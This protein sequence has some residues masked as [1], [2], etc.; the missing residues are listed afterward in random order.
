MEVEAARAGVC[1]YDDGVGWEFC[2][3]TV[4]SLT[5]ACWFAAGLCMSGWDSQ[6]TTGLPQ[7]LRLASRGKVLPRRKASP[8]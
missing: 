3:A 8:D 2:S 1:V 4:V 5:S 7:A 6:E